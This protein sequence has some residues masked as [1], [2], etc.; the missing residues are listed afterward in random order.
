M[1]VEQ[2]ACWGPRDRKLEEALAER[3][4]FQEEEENERTHVKV[5]EKSMSWQGVTRGRGGKPGQ[6]LSKEE[7]GSRYQLSKAAVRRVSRR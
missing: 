3:R 1:S 2:G 7:L 4:A 6:W 5:R